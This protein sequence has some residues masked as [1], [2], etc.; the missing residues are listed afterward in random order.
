MKR[1][2]V[3]VNMLFFRVFKTDTPILTV[4]EVFIAWVL[5]T[6]YQVNERCCYTIKTLK[7]KFNET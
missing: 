5:K 2:V 3:Y 4:H 1:T 7:A 6:N